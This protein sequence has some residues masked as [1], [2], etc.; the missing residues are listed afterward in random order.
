V[1]DSK[2]ATLE[3]GLL[4][5]PGDGSVCMIRSIDSDHDGA[6]LRLFGLHISSL[7]AEGTTGHGRFA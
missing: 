4:G 5:R 3:D 2:R 7:V 1:D 6:R